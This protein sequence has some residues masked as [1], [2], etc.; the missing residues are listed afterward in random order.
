MDILMDLYL[1]FSQFL[2]YAC[3]GFMLYYG[4]YFGLWV[5]L[6][7]KTGEMSELDHM[8]LLYLGLSIAF[9][10]AFWRYGGI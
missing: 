2:V 10:L 4:F 1:R 8:K 3:I 9:I 5:Y 7:R 6:W